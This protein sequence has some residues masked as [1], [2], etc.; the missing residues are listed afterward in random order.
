MRRRRTIVRKTFIDHLTPCIFCVQAQTAREHTYHW[1]PWHRSPPALLSPLIRLRFLLP[2]VAPIRFPEISLPLT[3]HT[4]TS[5]LPI[6]FIVGETNQKYSHYTRYVSSCARAHTHASS[7][8]RVILHQ[9]LYTS[10]SR[11][12]Y[13][14]PLEALQLQQR[15]AHSHGIPATLASAIIF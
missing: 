1:L 11:L 4:Y 14:P 15:C 9:P 2:I 10:F 6:H 5:S 13:A 12:M 8:D 3:F 7:H